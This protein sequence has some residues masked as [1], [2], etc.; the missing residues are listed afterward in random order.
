M[1]CVFLDQFRV[2][3]P[4]LNIKLTKISFLFLF[5]NKEL[6]T[7]QPAQTVSKRN[8]GLEASHRGRTRK[9]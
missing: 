8:T 1:F 9:K 7:Q 6:S 3:I 2:K 4:T 5:G